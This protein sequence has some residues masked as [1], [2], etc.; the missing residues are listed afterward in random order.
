MK[1]MFKLGSVLVLGVLLAAC[2]G[3]NEA[4]NDEPAEGAETAETFTGSA[5]GIGTVTATVT[6]DGD[7]NI[8]ALEVDASEENEIGQNGA[9][10]TAA[11]I[12]EAGND[13]VEVV[14]GATTSS[15][16]VIEAVQ[17]ALNQSA[18]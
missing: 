12:L 4:T 13:D 15:T 2:G 7:G 17:D 16:A 1:K 11:L 6:V 3:D 9:E 10:E 8:I 5:E 18:N 14:A